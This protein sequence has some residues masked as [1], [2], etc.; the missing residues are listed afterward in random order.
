MQFK[1]IITINNA[2]LYGGIIITA[3]AL[4]LLLLL[5]ASFTHQQSKN[6]SSAFR[7]AV[8]PAL[9]MKRKKDMHGKGNCPI[10]HTFFV[11]FPFLCLFI[12]VISELYAS[13][14]Y[15]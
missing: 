2:P 6:E 5:L 8:K 1:Q 15:I 12:P 13:A 10:A 14:T 4:L 3:R 11:P 7:V 9:L